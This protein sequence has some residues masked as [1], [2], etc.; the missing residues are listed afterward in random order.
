M[1]APRCPGDGHLLDWIAGGGL[2][3]VIMIALAIAVAAGAG[4]A[5]RLYAIPLAALSSI[6]AF[7]M[8]VSVRPLEARENLPEG[9]G[10]RQPGGGYRR[11]RAF[12]PE[13]SVLLTPATA[14]LAQ[15]AGLIFQ[16]RS[17]KR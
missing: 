12:G 3:F 7:A 13:L 14:L 1:V 6:F 9:R 8:F 11:R 10:N 17:S 5:S 15:A 2:G 16:G 4:E